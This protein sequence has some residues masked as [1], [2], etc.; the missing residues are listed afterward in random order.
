MGCPNIQIGQF[1]GIGKKVEGK[2]RLLLVRIN[3]MFEKFQILRNGQKLKGTNISVL[4]DL[5][6]ERKK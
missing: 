5:T 4:E 3:S 1:K 2:N 6:K